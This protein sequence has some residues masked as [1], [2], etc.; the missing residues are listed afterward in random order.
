MHISVR[1]YT[2]HDDRTTDEIVRI[3]QEGFVPIVSQAPGFI[4][5]YAFVAGDKVIASVSVFADEAGAEESNRRAADWV[6][7][8]LA[9]FVIGPPQVASGEVR[10]HATA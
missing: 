7:Q 4:S 10:V 5:Y 8:N 6:R 9:Q 2:I 3:V 1:R